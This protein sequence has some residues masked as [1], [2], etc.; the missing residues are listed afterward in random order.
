MKS[1]YQRNLEKSLFLDLDQVD[2][3]QYAVSKHEMLTPADFTT[4]LMD[5]FASD[6]NSKGCWLPFNSA[7]NLRFREGELSVIAGANFSGKSA[8]WGQAMLS[9]LRDTKFSDKPQKFLLIS[10]EMS[11]IQNLARLVQQC[12]AKPANQIQDSDVVAACV[13]LKDKLLILDHVG[14]IDVDDMVNTIHYATTLGVTAVLLDNLTVMRL[15]GGA[16]DVNH[17]Q[18]DMVT[19]LVE[20]ARASGVHLHVIAHTKKMAQGERTDR[21]SIRGSSTISDLADNVIMIERIFAKERKLADLNLSEEDREKWEACPDSKLLVSKQRHGTAWTGE[22]KLFYD[23]FSMRWS[24]Q[25]NA[26]FK[27]FEELRE[28]SE[29]GAGNSRGYQ[30]W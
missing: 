14:Q 19:Q 21:Y 27:A 6:P 30:S 11:P 3:S 4:D 12:V 1:D 20:C 7:S 9:F 28:L 29:L 10:P 8:M 2:L 23:P 16:A 25:R 5:W 26:A 18:Q 24:E 22:V 17:A 15:P 13:F